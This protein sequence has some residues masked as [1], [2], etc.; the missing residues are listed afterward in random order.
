MSDSK[1]VGQV[2]DGWLSG[3]IWANEGSNGTFFTVYFQRGY[4]D[5]DDIKNT[6]SMN[7]DDLLKLSNLAQ[8]A[9]NK[10]RGYKDVLRADKSSS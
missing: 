10:I 9:H 5:G 1:K 7:S 4:K 3:T 2:R 6:N 8:E